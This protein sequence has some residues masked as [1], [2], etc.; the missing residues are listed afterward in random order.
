MVDVY[1]ITDAVVTSSILA[2]LTIGLSLTYLTTRVPNFAHGSFASVGIYVG[3]VV[4]EVWGL[5]IYLGLIPGF[6]VGGLVAIAQYLLF[7]RPMTRRNASITTLMVATIAF[8]IFLV[9]ILNIFADYLSNA[10]HVESRYFQLFSLDFSLFGVKGLVFVSPILVVGVVVGLY[11]LLNKTKFGIAM[12]ATIENPPLAGTIGINTDMVYI[13]SWFLA[14]GIAG[15]AGSIT[16]LWYIGNTNVGSD[17]FLI[18]IFAAAVVG[19]VY[20]ING[21]IIGGIIIGAAQSLIIDFLAISIG[22]WIIPYQ[23]IIPLI[24]M[25][26]TLLIAPNGI[27]GINYTQLKK[28]LRRN[29]NAVNN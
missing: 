25:I 21:A 12:R 4:T 14:G 19:G 27:T 5:N 15:M 3:L 24:A 6:I 28:K 22:A 18:S 29:P 16:T 26:V 23:P 8:D 11:L 9:A 17:F 10:F 13:A 20:S 7:L 1:I 2:L